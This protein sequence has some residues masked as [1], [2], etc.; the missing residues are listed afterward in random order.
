MV[1]YS[2]TKVKA[3]RRVLTKSEQAAMQVGNHGANIVNVVDVPKSR[4]RPTPNQYC[5]KYYLYTR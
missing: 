4:G 5:Y 3:K 2:T 1:S